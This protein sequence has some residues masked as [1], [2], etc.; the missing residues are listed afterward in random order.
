MTA[1]TMINCYRG[2]L[3]RQRT[4]GHV[5][6]DVGRRRRGICRSLPDAVIGHITTAG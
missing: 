2:D 1:H 4:A 6:E 5:T 3:S